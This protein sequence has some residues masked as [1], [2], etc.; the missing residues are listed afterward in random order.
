MTSRLFRPIMT[1]FCVATLV[2][3]VPVLPVAPHVA[4]QETREGP[5]GLPVPRFVSLKSG[6]VNLREGPSDSHRILWTYKRRNLPVEVTAEFD[7]WRR[8]RDRDGVV[9]WI[10]KALLDGE[11]YV[12]I[13]ASTNVALLERADA[14]AAVEAWLEPGVLARLES[15]HGIWCE[16][17]IQGITGFVPRAELWGVYPA[18]EID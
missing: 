18:E 13:A 2:I 12:I 1:A 3:A 10:N 11:R 9:G 14:G 17:E 4:A 7:V 5:S 6:E 16:L 15:C 8:V